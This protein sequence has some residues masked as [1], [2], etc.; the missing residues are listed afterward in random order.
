MGP[1]IHRDFLVRS[2]RRFFGATDQRGH[3][4]AAAITP[5]PDRRPARTA[6]TVP[7]RPTNNLLFTGAGQIES[8][9]AG[10]ADSVN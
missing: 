10:R 2:Q 5:R 4:M 1:Y 6:N 7:D 9:T 3:A 8:R